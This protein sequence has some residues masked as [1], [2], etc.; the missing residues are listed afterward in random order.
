MIDIETMDKEKNTKI[1]I[2]RLIAPVISSRD[3]M[4]TLR[5]EINV[6]DTQV[7]SLDFKD[8]DFIS[9]SAAHELLSV[10]EDLVRKRDKKEIYF[11]N[12][13]NPV[14]DMFRATAANRAAPKSK[15][16]EFKAE[17]VDLTTLLKEVRI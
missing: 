15:E 6:T 17:E 8:V 13:N 10:K 4:G 1:N 14:R 7:V 5:T 3:V 11:V 2:A 16:P 12:L 9:R